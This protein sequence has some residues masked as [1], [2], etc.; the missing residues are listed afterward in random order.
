MQYYPLVVKHFVTPFPFFSY[1]DMDSLYCTVDM[2]CQVKPVVQVKVNH[3]AQEI[4]LRYVEYVNIV[5]CEPS[6]LR[7]DNIDTC[8]GFFKGNLQ[9]NYI[10]YIYL[11]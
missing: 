1:I 8:K 9:T 2:T 3:F 10:I 4:T 7:G 11:Y 6:W 5:I